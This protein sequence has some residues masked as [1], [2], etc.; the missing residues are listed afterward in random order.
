MER[1]YFRLKLDGFTDA[2]EFTGYAS[3][4]GNVDLGGDVVVNGA[5]A[6]TLKASGGAVPILWQ[7]DPRE[8]IGVS[9][10]MEEDGKGLRVKGKLVLETQRGAEAYALLK[11]GALRGLSI[12]YD[13][14]KD[15]VEKGVRYLLELKLYEF[16]IVTF[17]MNEAAQVEG[18]KSAQQIALTKFL[19]SFGTE[20]DR[21]QISA[22]RYAMLDTLNGI[23]GSCLYETEMTPEEV[24]ASLDASLAQ[25]HAAA[26][27]WADS[28]RAT[29]DAERAAGKS[30]QPDSSL[31]ESN[32]QVLRS[33][34]NLKALL[35][36]KGEKSDPA[37]SHS[38]DSTESTG[39]AADAPDDTVA[40][41][42][43]SLLISTIRAATPASLPSIY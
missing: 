17:P 39:P 30:F 19:P 43:L 41:S 9:I 2:G 4:S 13:C 16:S 40:V 3:R 12:G 37:Q 8:P 36:A 6:R 1:K 14:L 10:E 5:F 35:V 34:E 24:H 20:N 21:A 26:L 22:A 29:V 11:S 32:Q 27:S 33:I 18:V 42:D 15:R 23:L 38:G 31:V 28:A 25:F 7:H